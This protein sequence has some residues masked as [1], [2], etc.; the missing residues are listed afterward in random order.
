[1]SIQA[2]VKLGFTEDEA[3]TVKCYKGKGC[4]ACNNSGYK[5]RIGIYEVMP[6]K[7]EIKELTLEGASADEIKK[8][9]IKLGMKTLRMSALNKL[10]NGL[11]SVEEVLRT[12]F[13]D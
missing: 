8:T 5:G 10:K 11:T 7:D 9:A 13:G 2:L 1:M 6:M 4:P 12:T 3:K